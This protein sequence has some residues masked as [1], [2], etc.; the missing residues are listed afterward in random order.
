MGTIHNVFRRGRGRYQELF[1]IGIITVAVFYLQNNL[2]LQA[3]DMP[4]EVVF[5]TSHSELTLHTVARGRKGEQ[6]AQ[7]TRVQTSKTFTDS[8]NQLVL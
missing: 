2:I 7:N 4:T 1:V 6:E 8:T 3:D 5:Y